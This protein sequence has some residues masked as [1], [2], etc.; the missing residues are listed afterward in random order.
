MC[1][2]ATVM[3]NL[4]KTTFFFFIQMNNNTVIY[5]EVTG[6]AHVTKT[7]MGKNVLIYTLRLSGKQYPIY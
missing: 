4:I 5:S 2:S 3:E 1:V 6:A 7:L